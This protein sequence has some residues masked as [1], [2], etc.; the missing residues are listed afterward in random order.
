MGLLRPEEKI[1][2]RLAAGIFFFL[3][4]VTVLCIFSEE[5]SQPLTIPR[6]YSPVALEQGKLCELGK[7]NNKYLNQ[8][9]R[10][11]QGARVNVFDGFGHEFE[12]VIKYFT[13]NKV[14]LE[15]GASIEN[16]DR[17]IKI[18]LAQALPKA[19]KMDLIVRGAAELGAD[20]IIPFAAV[21]SVSRIAGEKISAK[22][23]RWQKIALDAAR[24]S[25]SSQITEVLPVADWETMLACA[26]KQ[27]LKMIFWE[28]EDQRSIKDILSD[29]SR[30]QTKNI[31]I[32]VGPEGGLS[33][34]EIS[35][36]R[37]VGFTSVSLGKQILKVETAAL[38]IIS[39][40][41]YEKGIFSSKGGENGCL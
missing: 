2:L 41:Q 29:Q 20:L 27:A 8:V 23:A 25:R 21:R 32:I 5:V 1:I 11:E 40:I 34:D 36:A 18:T 37:K 28:E 13:P 12:A 24:C 35:Q 6:I 17:K 3:L 19:G 4:Q 31:F 39:I 38:A 16:L 10:L 15:L 14:V 7:D 30:A 9:L 33:K 22:A 26:D